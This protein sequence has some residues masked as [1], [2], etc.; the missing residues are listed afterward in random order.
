MC[1]VC[2][3]RTASYSR[4]PFLDAWS[5]QDSYFLSVPSNILL[6]KPAILSNVNKTD[7]MFQKWESFSWTHGLPPQWSK[8]AWY[9]CITNGIYIYLIVCLSIL[10]ATYL[11][12][13]VYQVRCQFCW[14]A[15]LILMLHLPFLHGHLRIRM[16]LRSILF[17]SFSSSKLPS[18]SQNLRLIQLMELPS[19]YD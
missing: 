17:R 1:H 13:T 5:C 15:I 18:M 7:G 11:L 2:L 14:S 9:H 19:G 8:M 4:Y 6:N 3:A 16:V 12:A 10:Y